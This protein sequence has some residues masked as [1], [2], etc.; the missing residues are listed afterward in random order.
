ME[1]AMAPSFAECAGLA[2][3]R[4]ERGVRDQGRQI[5]PRSWAARNDYIQVVLGSSSQ[6]KTPSSH[7]TLCG[8]SPRLSRW[9]A[10]RLLE[11]QRHLMLMYTSCGWFFD[12]LTGPATLQILQYAARALQL[13]RQITSEDREEAF[14]QRLQEAWS[15][16]PGCGNGRHVFERFIKSTMLDLVRVGAHYAISSIFGGYHGRDSIFCYR[17]ALEK[18]QVLH[19]GKTKFAAGVA[20][21]TSDTT[22][23]S[24]R[25]GFGVLHFG[26]HN[27]SAGVRRLVTTH[28]LKNLRIRPVKR[29]P[30]PISPPACA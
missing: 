5:V 12:D 29:F 4:P 24:L 21:L 10:L 17:V 11:M 6:T 14:L 25:A 23:T 2:S 3:R 13:S 28:G 7:S 26:D 27:L 15:N 8:R 30:G 20:L 16:V 19:S 1:S 9:T 22:D 18:S